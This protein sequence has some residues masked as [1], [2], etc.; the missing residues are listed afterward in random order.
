LAV[1]LTAIYLIC[2]EMKLLVMRDLYRA[3]SNAR[4]EKIGN[5]KLI[6]KGNSIKC[7]RQEKAERGRELSSA[8][9]VIRFEQ[10]NKTCSCHFIRNNR[11]KKIKRVNK[12][13]IL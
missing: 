6:K 2:T 5:P 9:S 12:Y 3:K 8:I 10:E 7:C 4:L 11:E 1:I 13:K